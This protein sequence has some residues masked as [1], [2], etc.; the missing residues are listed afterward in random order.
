MKFNF[1]SNLDFPP[2]LNS[3]GFQDLVKVTSATKLLV[4]I[5]TDNLKWDSNT[6]F[7]CRKAYKKMWTL[8]RMNILDVYPYVILEVYTKEI[9]SV[10]ELTVPPWHSGLTQKQLQLRESKKWQCQLY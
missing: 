4:V 2:K 10:L 8:R 6:Q 1:S 5:V 7:I 3:N 9:R